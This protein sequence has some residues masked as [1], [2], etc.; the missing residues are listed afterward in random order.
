MNITN[1]NK[2]Y[3]SK[4]NVIYS[5]QYHVIFCTKYRR[6]ALTESIQ[7]RLKELIAEKALEYNYTILDMEIM[8][9]H[10]HLL[11]DIEPKLG[12]YQTI[13][14]IKGYSSRILR[15]EFPELK[16]RIPTLWTRSLFISSVGTVSLDMV[17]EYIANQKGV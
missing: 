11:I 15:E 9:D 7:Q 17:K 10:V 1:P 3:K 13:I 2:K 8:E 12:I 16:S 4:N 14:K 5:C 6:K